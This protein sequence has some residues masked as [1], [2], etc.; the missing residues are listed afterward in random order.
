[1]IGAFSS[2][3]ML[4]TILIFMLPAPYTRSLDATYRESYSRFLLQ[5][6]TFT[7]YQK[8]LFSNI[9]SIRMLK[10]LFP[11][12]FVSGVI[13]TYEGLLIQSFLYNGFYP[14][15]L[16][17]LP[18]NCVRFLFACFECKSCYGSSDFGSKSVRVCGSMIIFFM[19][20]IIGI[21]GIVLY[22]EQ[23]VTSIDLFD[24]WD[25]A[26]YLF[27]G[28]FGLMSILVEKQR[29]SLSLQRQNDALFYRATLIV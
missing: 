27:S 8:N 26:V 15:L 29:K 18:Y 6:G 12:L 5:M 1:M 28:F 2:L 17:L 4:A 24:D 10:H 25:W 11:I 13:F 7:A 21:F 14:A 16:M 9:F 23:H 3:S 19:L 20:I 22:I